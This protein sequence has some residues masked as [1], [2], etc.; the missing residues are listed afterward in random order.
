MIGYRKVR[1][2]YL[3]T[4]SLAKSE[5]LGAANGLMFAVPNWRMTEP[6]SQRAKCEN[7]SI[8]SDQVI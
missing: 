3:K 7:I 4:E 2:S 6:V 8:D 5:A 1:A